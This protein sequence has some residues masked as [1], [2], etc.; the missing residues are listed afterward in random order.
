MELRGKTELIERFRAGDRALLAELYRAHVAA[1]EA[2]LSQGFS[3]SSKGQPVRFRGFREP[4]RLQEAVQESFVHGF[5]AKAREGYDG[6]QPYRPYLMTIARNRV[7]DG[8]RREGLEA[9]WFVRGADVAAEDESAQD[10]VDRLARRGEP[11]GPEVEAMRAELS[12]ALQRFVQGLDGADAL[13]LRRHLMGE[14]TQNGVAE[15]LGVDRN[16]VRRRIREMRERLLR[17]LKREGLIGSLDVGE[18]LRT[19]L[20]VCLALRAGR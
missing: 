14:L 1:V 10:A 12:A 6:S 3:F 2:M 18:A 17:H 20:M 7:I 11:E 5:R 9:R 4:F 16:E 8:F 15:A 19:V 13:I